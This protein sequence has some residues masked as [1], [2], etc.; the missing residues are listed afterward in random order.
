MSKLRCLLFGH[1]Y[2]KGDLLFSNRGPRTEFYCIRCGKRK[3]V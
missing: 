2:V 3:V 1:H